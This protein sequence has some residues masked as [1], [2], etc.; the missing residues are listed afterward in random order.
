M[1]RLRECVDVI[2]HSISPIL[3]SF[4]IEVTTILAAAL[5]ATRAFRAESTLHF[6][7]FLV[8]GLSLFRVSTLSRGWSNTFFYAFHGCEFDF[9][10]NGTLSYALEACPSHSSSTSGWQKVQ[11]ILFFA[12]FVVNST[13]LGGSLFIGSI[14]SSFLRALRKRSL[15]QKLMLPQQLKLELWTREHIYYSPKSIITMN[16]FILVGACTAGL[17]LTFRSKILALLHK[18]LSVAFCIEL[19]IRMMKDMRRY[20]RSWWNLFDLVVLTIEVSSIFSTYRYLYV[21]SVLRLAHFFELGHSS[22][23]NTMKLV[24]LTLY[25]NIQSVLFLCSA[26]G[27]ILYIF[28]SFGMI[29]FAENDPY[30]ATVHSAARTLLRCGS[31][32]NWEGIM[33][34]NIFGCNRYPADNGSQESCERSSPIGW[35]AAV[36]F[37]VCV[38]SSLLLISV[39]IG[40]MY[41]SLEDAT[42]KMDH[43][44]ISLMLHQSA[45][46]LTF[47][48]KESSRIE[49]SDT[50]AIGKKVDSPIGTM[51]SENDCTVLKILVEEFYRKKI[52][53]ES[54]VSSA[55]TSN[56]NESISLNCYDN[57]SRASD[58][59]L[60]VREAVQAGT[61]RIHDIAEHVEEVLSCRAFSDKEAF[62]VWRQICFEFAK[63]QKLKDNGSI[64]EANVDIILQKQSSGPC[65]VK[66]H[67]LRSMLSA[68]LLEEKRLANLTK[69]LES[70]HLTLVDVAADRIRLHRDVETLRWDEISHTKK[71]LEAKVK[72]REAEIVALKKRCS[73]I[74]GE[75]QQNSDR[76]LNCQKLGRL[77]V[78]INIQLKRIQSFYEFRVAVA[79]AQLKIFAVQQ[80]HKILISQRARCL[81]LTLRWHVDKILS[82]ALHRWWA[83]YAIDKRSDRSSLADRATI[84][85]TE[86]DIIA[87]EKKTRAEAWSKAAEAIRVANEAAKASDSRASK[88]EAQLLAMKEKLREKQKAL[89]EM[90]IAV[91]KQQVNMEALDQDFTNEV[92]TPQEADGGHGIACSNLSMEEDLKNLMEAKRPK[93]YH[94]MVKLEEPQESITEQRMPETATLPKVLQ[95]ATEPR[96]RQR[97][98]TKKRNHRTIPPPPRLSAFRERL[99]LRN[100]G[101]ARA[102]FHAARGLLRAQSGLFDKPGS[103]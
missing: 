2:Q 38:C 53:L 39:F 35:T 49:M 69:Q 21:A 11:A 97:K 68:L 73:L 101:K 82:R 24:N 86:A 57:I 93:A 7:S 3:C 36:F 88:A 89:E 64:P 8:S 5:F 16:T 29:L 58:I 10:M 100:K 34:T 13:Y 12:V 55:L 54:K 87:T 18:S 30:F 26:I 74:E 41:V 76:H 78:I 81:F 6:S 48:T 28:G 17:R 92:V 1:K 45:F 70:L 95:V 9:M 31:A 15:S 67:H 75:Q 84:T 63:I 56:A 72:E 90:S 23:R 96:D 20:F 62:K 80:S 83:L 99:R 66:N 91:K 4:G 59:M 52:T 102:G 71:A 14:L 60:E 85:V 42:A 33:F 19:M 51:L 43:E 103:I 47:A 44:N 65:K 32:E 27:L 25:Q 77:R 79:F 22:N 46:L 40:I 98:K 50:E 61:M 37:V 94:R